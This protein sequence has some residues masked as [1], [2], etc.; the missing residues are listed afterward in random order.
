ARADESFEFLSE[1]ETSPH[2]GG[3]RMRSSR[4]GVCGTPT[5]DVDHRDSRTRLT[6]EVPMPCAVHSELSRS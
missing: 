1:L 2:I 3:K 4:S 5:E 6:P